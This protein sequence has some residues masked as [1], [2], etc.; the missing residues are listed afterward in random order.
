MEKRKIRLAIKVKV[1]LSSWILQIVFLLWIFLLF[2][3]FAKINYGDKDLGLGNTDP[4][5][6]TSA[7]VL[8]ERLI[9]P[10]PPT[11]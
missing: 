9:S 5:E 6:S 2:V 7:Y 10:N 11:E 3:I 8:P 1:W 4:N